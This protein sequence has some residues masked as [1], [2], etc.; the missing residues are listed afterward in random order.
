MNSVKQSVAIR[1]YVGL[2]V[3]ARSIAIAV[4][5]AVGGDA[6]SVGVVG[7]DWSTVKSA[8]DKLGKPATLSIAYEAGPTGYGLYRRLRDEGCGVIVV[9]PSLIPR[10]PGDRVKTDRRDA[11][12]LARL[13]RAGEL[14]AVAVPTVDDEAMRDLCRAREDA[15]NARQT[16]RQL[17]KALLLRHGIRYA[18]KTSWTKS[19]QRWLGTLKL[20]DPIQQIVF[21]EYWQ[22]VQR[23]DEQVARL[24]TALRERLPQW[25][26][27]PLVTALM[28]L[29]GF[30]LIAASTVVAEI[31]DFERFAHPRSLMKF[32]GLIPSEH[33]SGERQH[34]G[35]ITRAGNA[36]V[37]RMLVE[38]A[39]N[40]RFGARIGH[41]LTRRQEDQPDAIRSLSWK[42]QLR[43]CKRYRALIARG[44]HQNKVC[45]AVARELTGFIWAIARAHA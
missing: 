36:H 27:A 26:R 40:Y 44:L 20:P 35:A 28:T 18:G 22:A 32:I 45:V 10:R 5:D 31:G 33:S 24:T 43:L 16:A 8:L 3:H 38:A 42:A 6:R 17:L 37:R 30:D 15:I 34:R 11:L 2:D 25:S 7:S 23:A 14:T 9:A 29:R 1:K 4:A 13:L 12:L 39:W 41:A 19:H 21:T